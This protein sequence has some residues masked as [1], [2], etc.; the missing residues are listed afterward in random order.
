MF[1]HAFREF[2][3]EAFFA[4]LPETAFLETRIDGGQYS[5]AYCWVRT[6]LKTIEEQ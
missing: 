1:D 5:L 3:L 6:I 2:E 4:V